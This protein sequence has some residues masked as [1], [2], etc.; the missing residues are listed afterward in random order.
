MIYLLYIIMIANLYHR[1]ACFDFSNT[2]L[3]LSISTIYSSALMHHH[4][5]PKVNQ[6]SRYEGSCRKGACTEGMNRFEVATKVGLL[7]SSHD[8]CEWLMTMVIVS[9]QDLGL[10]DPF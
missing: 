10:W 1:H 7:G 2:F 3:G 5:I 6:K 9:P 8:G 4:Q